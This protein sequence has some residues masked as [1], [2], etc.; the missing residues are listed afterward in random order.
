MCLGHGCL[1]DG[2]TKL[3]FG[4]MILQDLFDFEGVLVSGECLEGFT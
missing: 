3:D 4:V 1:L 2:V